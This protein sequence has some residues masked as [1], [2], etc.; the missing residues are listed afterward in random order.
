VAAD[1]GLITARAVAAA[2]GT[3]PCGPARLI[4]WWQGLLR[5]LEHRG[6][7]ERD[8]RRHGVALRREAERGAIGAADAAASVDEGIEHQVEELVGELE[9]DALRAGGGFAGKLV[10]GVGQIVAG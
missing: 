10:Q 1:H 4:D 9:A 7:S 6:I 8:L 3:A 2:I 5:R